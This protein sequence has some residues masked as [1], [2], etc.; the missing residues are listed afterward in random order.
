MLAACGDDDDSALEITVDGYGETATFDIRLEYASKWS[1]KSTWSSLC[2]PADGEFVYIPKGLNL[3]VDDATTPATGRLSGILVEGS[4]IAQPDTEVPIRTINTDN[5]I[6]RGG[7]VEFGSEEHPYDEGKLFLNFHSD[8]YGGKIPMFGNKVL[9][10]TSGCLNIHGKPRG[11]TCT[12]LLETARINH[13]FIMISL[14][15]PED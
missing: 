14:P 1:D 7:E 9:G 2:P 8:T 6:V 10:V 4:L 15:L 3:L 11:P 13:E 12:K 5:I